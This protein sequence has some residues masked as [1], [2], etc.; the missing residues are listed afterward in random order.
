[1]TKSEDEEAKSQRRNKKLSPTLAVLFII[2]IFIILDYVTRESNYSNIE[3]LKYNDSYL[4]WPLAVIL[5]YLVF[6]RYLK[7][8]RITSLES[9]EDSS[10]STENKKSNYIL[11]SLIFLITYLLQIK[12]VTYSLNDDFGDLRKA[13]EL[14]LHYIFNSVIIAYFVLIMRSDSAFHLEIN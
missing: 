5:I 11:G 4:F 3:F 2:L 1:M 12:Y 9:S 14:H 13:F 6:R 10:T 8:N 7:I